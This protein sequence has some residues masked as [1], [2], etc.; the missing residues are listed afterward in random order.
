[1][2]AGMHQRPNDCSCYRKIPSEVIWT[3]LQSG[4]GLGLLSH[5]ELQCLYLT[6]LMSRQ[7][8]GNVSHT[9]LQ[10]ST[11]ISLPPCFFPI[12]CA[13]A[14]FVMGLTSILHTQSCCTC[15]GRSAGVPEVLMVLKFNRCSCTQGWEIWHSQRGTM[16]MSEKTRSE[17]PC[18]APFC[19]LYLHY[20]SSFE[21][22]GCC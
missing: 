10:L 2:R 21:A 12:P 9:L 18:R 13:A 11:V 22:T 1:M 16:E 15:K 20:C 3:P 6:E 5:A 14:E 7:C 4:A 19:S 17:Q 8:R